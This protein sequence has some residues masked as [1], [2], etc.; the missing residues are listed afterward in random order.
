MY[1]HKCIPATRVFTNRLQQALRDAKENIVKITSEVCRD[2]RWFVEFIPKF[3]GTATYVH[4]FP[5]ASHTIALDASLVRVGGVWNGQVYTA[6]IPE[7][8]KANRSIVHFEMINLLVA[9]NVWKEDWK[10]RCVKFLVDNM[11]VVNVCNSSF[12]RDSFLATC[13]RNIWMLTSVY[14]IKLVVTHIAGYCN[15]TADLLSRW[16]DSEANHNKLKQLISQRSW[17]FV[18]SAYFLL[19]HDI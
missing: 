11:A 13:I 12:S 16:E 19:N 3:N 8:V 6:K 7:H 17:I 4:N 5:E 14:D 15:T 9:L 2:I 10:G 1:I 18:P